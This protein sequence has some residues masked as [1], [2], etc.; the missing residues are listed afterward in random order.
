MPDLTR[1]SRWGA[2]R[3]WAYL[4]PAAAVLFLF[5]LYPLIFVV[6]VSLYRDWG[7]PGAAFVGM[8]NYRSIFAGGEFVESLGITLWY[9]AGAVPLSIGLALVL[10]VMI[11]NVRERRVYRALF[12]LPFVTSTV[13]SAA[14]WKWILHVDGRGLANGML[15]WVGAG[16]WRFTEEGRGIFLLATG[17]PIPFLG[18]GPSLALVAVIAFAVWQVLGFYVL[19]FSAGLAQIPLEVY[20]AASLDGAGPVRMFFVIT[21]PLLRPVIA[22]LVVVSLLGAFQIFNPIYIMAPAERLHSCRNATMYIVTRF[23]DY[24]RTGEGAAASVLLFGFLVGLTALQVWLHRRR[25]EA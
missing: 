2:F 3:P 12:F 23:W 13:A 15:G 4:L 16:P 10:A 5:H 9:A 14:V 7:T 19:L 22:F 21:L 20:E 6:L 1:E 25:G 24:G 11:Q 17:H 18:E 8:A